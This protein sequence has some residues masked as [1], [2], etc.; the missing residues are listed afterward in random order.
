M[1]YLGVSPPECEASL[2]Q[3]AHEHVCHSYY[4][5]HVYNSTVPT[6]EDTNIYI[7]LMHSE[8]HCQGAFPLSRNF[9]YSAV[10]K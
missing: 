10:Q 9:T 7:L 2:L 5:V 6:H 1:K 8:R 4:I 3:E